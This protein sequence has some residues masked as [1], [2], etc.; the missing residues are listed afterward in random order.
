MHR[1]YPKNTRLRYFVF[2]AATMMVGIIGFSIICDAFYRPK[3]SVYRVDDVIG[4]WRHTFYMTY[5]HPMVADVTLTFD[6]NGKFHER[7]VSDQQAS[8]IDAEG[9]WTMDPR[10]EVWL[11]GALEYSFNGTWSRGDPS[12]DLKEIG[13]DAQSGGW[14]DRDHETWMQGGIIGDPDCDEYWQRESWN[15][16]RDSH[17]A[18]TQPAPPELMPADSK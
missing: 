5:P 4:K 8:P 9:S 11:T 15:R 16:K 13:G 1:L 2:G 6:R 18:A 17:G 14:R 12:F 10:G 3:P 7:A